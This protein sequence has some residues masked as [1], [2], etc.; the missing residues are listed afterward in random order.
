MNYTTTRS[1]DVPFYLPSP[2]APVYDFLD[3]VVSLHPTF[4][5]VEAI[6]TIY[7]S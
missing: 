2:L 4:P 1:H 6:T 3:V 7:D 5:V